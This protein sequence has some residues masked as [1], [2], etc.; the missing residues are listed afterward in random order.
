MRTVIIHTTCPFCSRTKQVLVPEHQYDAF[1]VTGSMDVFT[2]LS[3]EDRERL[4]SGTCPTC[5][6]EE[7]EDDDRH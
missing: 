1:L 6:S 5:F 3:L 2:A 7:D 4:I